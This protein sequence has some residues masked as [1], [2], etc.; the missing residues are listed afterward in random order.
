MQRETTEPF[1]LAEGPLIRVRLVREAADLYRL[2]LTVHH[3]VCDGWSSAVLFSDLAAAYAAGRFGLAARLPK[4]MSYQEYITS[5]LARTDAAADEAYWLE[6]LAGDPPSL[7][8][9]LDH[10]RQAARTHLGA[11]ETLRIDPILREQIKAV[12]AS[13]GATLFHTLLAAFETLMFRLSGQSDLVIGIPVA[14]QSELENGH[15]VAHCVATLPL[16]CRINADASF[17]EFLKDL[18]SSFLDARAHSN[19]TFGSL[20]SK[21][22]IERDPSRPPLV[23][24]VFNIDRIGAAFDFGDLTLNRVETPKRFVTFDLNVNVVELGYRA[25]RRMRLQHRSPGTR[26]DPALARP[27]PGLA[28]CDRARARADHILPRYP[29]GRG[30]P[31]APARMEPHRSSAAGSA[32]HSPP[33][34]GASGP[35]T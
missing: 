13:R 30:A 22:P 23:S 19:V 20:I 18:R 21:L 29:V 24:V 11:R 35:N 8:L 17:S 9:P 5:E 4:P 12:G 28:R 26:H 14:G 25:A 2:V 15:L 33:L 6:R 34:R 10:K 1:N 16:R 31:R 32:A 7:D 27:F 3:L